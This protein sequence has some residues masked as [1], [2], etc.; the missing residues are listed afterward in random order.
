MATGDTAV[1]SLIVTALGSKPYPITAQYIAKL[2]NLDK[3]AV[4]RVLAANQGQF[5][6]L[7][8]SPPLWRIRVPGTPVPGTPTIQPV[9]ATEPVDEE[10]A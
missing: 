10:D 3:K 1:L 6:K 5:E 2:M 7:D 4:N 8:C 9:A